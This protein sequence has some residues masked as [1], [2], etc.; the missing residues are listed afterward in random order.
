MHIS[1]SLNSLD[2]RANYYQWALFCFGL[3]FSSA[4]FRS[5][6]WDQ[7]CKYFYPKVTFKWCKQ[8]YF[9]TLLP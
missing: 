4:P 8:P 6:I 5:S 1:L 7:P 3:T 9:P 2:R